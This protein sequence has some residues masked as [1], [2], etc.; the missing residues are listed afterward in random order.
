[1]LMLV[2]VYNGGVS[3]SSLENNP[4]TYTEMLLELTQE[5]KK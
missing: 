5:N 2:R 1:M 4:W 3:L